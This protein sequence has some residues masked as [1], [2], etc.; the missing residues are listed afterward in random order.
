MI[1][2]SCGTGHDDVSRTKMRAI[3]LILLSYLSF[4][5]FYAYLCA[6]CNLNTLWNIIMIL[7]SYVELVMTMSRV[8]E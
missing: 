6:L 2:E 7:H 8:Q 3:A 1:L 4:D 5:A